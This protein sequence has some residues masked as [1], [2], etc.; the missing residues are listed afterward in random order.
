MKYTVAI[1][2]DLPRDRVVELL[3][4]PAYLPHWL[5]GLVSHEPVSGVHGQE[6][7]VSR[8]VLSSGGQ[9]MEATETVTR[10][11]LAGDVMYYERELAGAGMWNA[12][13]ERLTA[14]GPASTRWVSEN[15]FR[16]DG[17]MMRLVGLL[18]PGTFRKQ[19]L[20]HMHDF[21]AFAEHGRD[22]RDP[23]S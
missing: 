2:I 17:L 8:V 18:M 13:R 21:K 7:T 1:E 6:G 20:Q 14:S 9:R 16:F 23:N 22:V 12:A 3:A 5:R 10:R 15:E 4:D 19:S 11:E